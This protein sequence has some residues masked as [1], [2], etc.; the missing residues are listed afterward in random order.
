VQQYWLKT[1][2]VNAVNDFEMD[3]AEVRELKSVLKELE[4]KEEAAGVALVDNSEYHD[5]LISMIERHECERALARRLEVFFRQDRVAF[6]N[7]IASSERLRDSVA[8]G[9]R[10]LE[11]LT[12]DDRVASNVLALRGMHQR[13][14]EIVESR[15][16]NLREID[17]RIESAASTQAL[18]SEIIADAQRTLALVV[19]ERPLLEEDLEAAQD[20]TRQHQKLV[21][22]A[23]SRQANGQW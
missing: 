10:V 23:Q 1:F 18:S 22:A 16:E 6:P 5:T 13:H 8:Q 3:S 19:E 4:A 21:Q 9:L 12:Q 11:I 15:D 17:A 14:S 20:A 7:R 2:S